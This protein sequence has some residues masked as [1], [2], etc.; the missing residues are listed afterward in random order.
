MAELEDIH[1]NQE[2]SIM[3][4]FHNVEKTIE[5]IED[6]CKF[7]ERVLKSGNETEVT[8]ALDILSLCLE[9][10]VPFKSQDVL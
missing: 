6:G 3:D 5:K 10:F 8:F 9:Y 2:L 1:T 7:A 4:V